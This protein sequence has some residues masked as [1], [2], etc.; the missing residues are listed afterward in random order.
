MALTFYTPSDVQVIPLA[1]Q[2]FDDSVLVASCAFLLELC[3]LSAS[4]LRMDIAALR[5]ISSFYKSAENNQYRQ[6]SPRSPAFLQ[7]PVEVDV[8]ESIARALADDYL[9]KYSSSVMQKGDRKNSILNQP[10]R[11]LLLVLQHLEKASLPLASNGMTCGSWL[12]S[13]NG[14]GADLR[15]QQKATSQHWQLVTAFC[16]THNIPLSTKY[17]AVLARDN[18]WV[19]YLFCFLIH[20][21]LNNVF[22][23]AKSKVIYVCNPDTGWLFVRSS[24]REISF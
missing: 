24:S 7:P 14:D 8:T 16:Q 15:S 20:Y 6:Q 3:G 19:H 1:I 12:S 23:V 22:L 10:S 2:H 13:G 17:L 18:D 9:H 5:R 21:L 4:T 11:A